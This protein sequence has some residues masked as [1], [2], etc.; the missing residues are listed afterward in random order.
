[1]CNFFYI[2]A[3]TWIFI[4]IPMVTLRVHSHVSTFHVQCVMWLLNLREFFSTSKQRKTV[5]V[6]IIYSKF[7][8]IYII[9]V[10]LIEK[11]KWM[12]QCLIL[13]EE[14]VVS[15]VILNKLENDCIFVRGSR[16][17]G[18]PNP[19]PPPPLENS[20]LF[21]SQSFGSAQVVQPL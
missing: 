14:V 18:G 20:N 6:L 9:D 16:L 17:G 2:H 15:K 19:C 21:N 13:F 12:R 4:V 7:R 11:C 3:C 1:M 10:R 8:R 5:W